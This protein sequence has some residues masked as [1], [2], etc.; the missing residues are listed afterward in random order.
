M[1]LDELL[2]PV[3]LVSLE[4]LSFWISG[5]GGLWELLATLG[6]GVCDDAAVRVG[7]KTL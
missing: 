2:R 4:G 3:F 1:S 6:Q 7:S 5:A